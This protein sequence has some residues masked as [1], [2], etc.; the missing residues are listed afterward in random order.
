[1]CAKRTF[2]SLARGHLSQFILCMCAQRA[3]AGL[4]HS[5]FSKNIT[6]QHFEGYKKRH[7]AFWRDF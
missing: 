7:C 3:Y 4:A 2:G 1:M 6:V 5:D